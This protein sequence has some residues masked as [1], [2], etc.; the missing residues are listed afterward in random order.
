VDEGIS[1]AGEVAAAI[2]A[3]VQGIQVVAP[4]LEVE[5]ALAVLKGMG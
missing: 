2:K 4:A 3:H 5:S 1:I